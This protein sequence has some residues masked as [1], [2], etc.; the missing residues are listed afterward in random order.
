MW[1]GATAADGLRA[2]GHCIRCGGQVTFSEATPEP[3]EE[4]VDPAL[5]PHQVLGPPRLDF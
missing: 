4:H 2:L 3:P 5:G 1:Y